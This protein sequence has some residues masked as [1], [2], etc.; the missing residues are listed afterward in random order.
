[1][2]A[3]MLISF[4]IIWT[5]QNKGKTTMNRKGQQT[6]R[7]LEHE[8]GNAFSDQN[9]RKAP[10]QKA[11]RGKGN[12]RERCTSGRSPGNPIWGGESVIQIYLYEGGEF[13]GP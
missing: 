13:L 1:M 4:A 10:G 11:E 7:P 5:L 6:G 2:G 9:S 8:T 3:G 12:G